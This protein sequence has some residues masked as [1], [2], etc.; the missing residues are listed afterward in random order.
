MV[1]V[2]LLVGLTAVLAAA[3]GVG[4][5]VATTDGPAPQ[6]RVTGELSAADTYP[7]GQVLALTHEAG[8]ALDPSAVALSVTIARTGEQARLTGFPTRR[9]T[10]GNVHGAG[11]FDASYAGVDGAVDAAHADGAWT[12]GERVAVRIAR[13]EHDVRPG[14]RVRV[15]VIHEPTDAVV[16]DL[17]VTAT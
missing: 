6:V 17:W 13:R 10:G 7:D 1:G 14:D 4:V 3:V 15:R 16:A 5:G 9:L 11:V 12:S 8:D 2:V